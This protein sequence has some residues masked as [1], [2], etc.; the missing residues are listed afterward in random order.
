MATDDAGQTPNLMRKRAYARYR[1]RSP[2][3]VSGWIRRGWIVLE[4]GLVDVARSDA[5]LDANLDPGLGARAGSP[6]EKRGPGRTK[7]PPSSLAVAAAA[8]REAGV[9]LKNLRLDVEAEGLLDAG[10]ANRGA[11]KAQAVVEAHLRELPARIGALL[12][13]RFNVD[14]RQSIALFADEAELILN[15]LGSRLDEHIAEFTPRNAAAR[16][17]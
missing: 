11:R 8:D 15:E 10:A 14:P 2:A 1:S 12:A 3:S 7:G 4:G 5:L 17:N 6:P 16:G 13:K 9:R